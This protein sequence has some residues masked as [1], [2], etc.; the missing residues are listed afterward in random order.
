[1]GKKL[2][3]YIRNEFPNNSNL[4]S[5]EIFIKILLSKRD[6][7]SSAQER[8]WWSL[9]TR[10][11]MANLERL[12]CSLELLAGF[13]AFLNLPGLWPV[14]KLGALGPLLDLQYD[15]VGLR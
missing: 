13:K 2:V 6:I 7:S 1:M 10:A 8:P 3:D 11:K 4:L 12:F 9:R 15:K 5:G 14:A